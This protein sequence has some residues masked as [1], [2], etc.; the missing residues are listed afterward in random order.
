[1]ERPHRRT[2]TW[3]WM[4]KGRWQ[5]STTQDGT[6]PN[7]STRPRS[8]Y[9]EGYNE[10][11][12]QI[13]TLRWPGAPGNTWNGAKPSTANGGAI[14]IQGRAAIIWH[15]QE[16]LNLHQPAHQLLWAASNRL[17][18][19]VF[20]RASHIR[21]YLSSSPFRWFLRA[22]HTHAISEVCDWDEAVF[23]GQETWGGGVL[24]T[25]W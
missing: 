3:Y 24:L 1:M 25:S 6:T 2:W 4:M 20:A 15:N 5:S 8:Y 16:L 14:P 23:P 9:R 18:G 12:R 13:V 22:G 21:Y 10:R 17:V 7:L 11:E 19:G